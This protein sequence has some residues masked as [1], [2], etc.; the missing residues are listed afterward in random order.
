MLYAY[1]SG[2]SAQ[3]AEASLSDQQIEEEVLSSL[4][5]IFGQEIP[6][7]RQVVISRW[8]QDEFSKGSYSFNQLGSS[9]KHRRELA[10]PLKDRVYFAGEATHVEHFATAQGALFSGIKAAK[11]ILPVLKRSKKV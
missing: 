4:S 11:Q 7:P 1:I 8:G 3:E 6:K 9:P 5:S 10:R 2:K